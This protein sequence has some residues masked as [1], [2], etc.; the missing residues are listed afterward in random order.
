VDNNNVSRIVFLDNIRYLMVLLVVILHAGCAY[1]KF[2]PWWAV[3]DIN[4]DMIDYLLA[5][6]D[7]FL[8]PVLFFIA[9]YFAFPSLHK[10]GTMAFLRGKCRRLGL[11]WVVGVFLLPPLIN[12]I[13]LFSRQ[14]PTIQLGLWNLFMVNARGFFSFTTGVIETPLQFHHYYFW[15]I[16][17]L[18]LFFIVF[19]LAHTFKNRWYYG[20]ATPRKP[21]P[22]TASIVLVVGAAALLASGITLLIH[23]LIGESPN[24]DPWVIVA[25]LVQF[26]ATRIGVYVVCFGL[27]IWAN[28]SRWFEGGRAPGHWGLWAVLVI[29]LMAGYIA[30]GMRLFVSFTPALAVG[31]VFMRTF[32]VFAALLAIVSF[33]LRYWNRPTRINRA[34]AANSYHIYLLHMIFVV[35]LQL[36]LLQY[37]DLSVLVKLAV[38][39][40]LAISLAFFSSHRLVRPFPGRSIG[41]MVLLFALLVAILHPSAG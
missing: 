2:I 27:G 26:Q 24:K 20:R 37:S 28:S 1:S 23:V 7:V 14:D 3:N 16:S 15:F 38:I 4:A 18:L 30:A 9:G 5:I 22:K 13:Y 10:K 34:L 8:M 32:A 19:A 40:L 29:V 25:S 31:W 35:G 39:S 21:R 41:G 12:Y 11:P 36:F 6:L 33:G 17:L